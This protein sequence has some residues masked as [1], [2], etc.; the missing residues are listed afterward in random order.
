MI[1]SDKIQKLIANQEGWTRRMFEEG[2]RIKKQYGEENVYDFSLGNPDTEPPEEV[3]KTLVETLSNPVKGMHRYM[4]NNGYEDVREEIATYLREQHGVPFTANHIFM[5]VGCA[6]GL[7]ILLKS[8]LSKGNEVIVPSPFFWEFKNYIENHGGVMRLVQTKKDFQLDIEKIE[9][10]I[11]KKTKAILL[12]SP[13]NPTGAVYT[14][15]SVKGLIGLLNAKRA[16]GQD[17][18]I[19][20]D[21]AYKKLVYD[22]LRLPNLF[23][24]YDL[25][26]AVTSHSKDLA[27]PGERIGYVAISPRVPDYELMVSG[28]MISMR[29]LGF[30]NAPALFQRIAGKF[31]RTSVNIGDYARKRDVLYEILMEAGFECVKPAGAFY[32]FPKS[33]IPDE[34][35]FIRTLQQEERIMVV[36]G[37]GFGRKGYFRIAYC[38]PMET[39]QKSREGF[40]RIGKRYKKR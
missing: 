27:L 8:M 3:Q 22:G 36:P 1:I 26:Y 6:G 29:T 16:Q 33:P 34:L 13:N 15:E 24:L 32:M 38:V 7:N 14:E 19:I 23:G 28:L 12:N 17:I 2:L 39:I 21:D 11:T 40:I 30:V 18:Y 37:R 4:S 5:T 10:V 9:K 31:Q 20:C 25:V 35:E